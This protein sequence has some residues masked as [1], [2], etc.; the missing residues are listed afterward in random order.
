MRQGSV[1]RIGD[2]RLDG[3]LRRLTLDASGEPVP[4]GSRAF[5]VLLHLTERPGVLVGKAELMQAGWPD[6]TVEENSLAQ[7]ISSIRKALGPSAGHIVTEA[8]RGYRFVAAEGGASVAK[9]NR[10]TASPAAYQAY[11]SGWYAQSRP[12]RE[13]LQRAMECYSKAIAID[14]EFALAHVGVADCFSLLAVFGYARARAVT[15]QARAAIQRALDLGGA[16][17]EALGALGHLEAML[18]LK[19][20]VA[21]AT[22]RRALEINPDSPL[23]LFNMGLVNQMQGRM[24]EAAIYVSRAQ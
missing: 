12:G 1:I 22:L 21:E 13:S 6:V 8:G 9:S 5:S 24:D 11:V 7:C 20:A 23:V 3:D 15:E 16:E 18:E 10:T 14:P 2:C 4:L 17:A 19:P